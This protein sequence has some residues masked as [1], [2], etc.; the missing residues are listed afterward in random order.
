MKSIERR[1]RRMEEELEELNVP[2]C[3]YPDW[4]KFLKGF[5]PEVF[6]DTDKVYLR[7]KDRPKLGMQLMLRR[8]DDETLHRFRDYLE[9]EF[10]ETAV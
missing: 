5:A 7:Y 1:I 6:K 10:G 9:K 2:G 4:Y 8:L 3:D